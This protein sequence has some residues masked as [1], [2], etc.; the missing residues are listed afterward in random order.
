[1]KAKELSEVLKNRDNPIY[2]KVE[3]GLYYPITKIK[4]EGNNII[5]VCPDLTYRAK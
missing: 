2:V 5:L 3:N 4:Q 1:M